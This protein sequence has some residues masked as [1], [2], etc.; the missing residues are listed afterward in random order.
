MKAEGGKGKAMG[1]FHVI[2]G[3]S[4]KNGISNVDG[5]GTLDLRGLNSLLVADLDY[6]A[7]HHIEILKLVEKQIDRRNHFREHPEKLKK[8][9]DEARK[10][11]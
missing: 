3:T 4:P 2:C 8:L 9:M 11:K 1:G 7:T 5:G 6:F 10:A